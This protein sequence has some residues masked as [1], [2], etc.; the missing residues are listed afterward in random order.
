MTEMTLEN[1]TEFIPPA[2]SECPLRYAAQRYPQGEALRCGAQWFDFASLDSEVSQLSQWAA[3]Q[4]LQRGQR[5]LLISEDK[6]LILRLLLVALRAGACLVVVN[7]RAPVAQL[8]RQLHHCRPQ[9]LIDPDAAL[10]AAPETM[11]GVPRWWPPALAAVTTHTPG[12]PQSLPRIAVDPNLPLSGVFTSGSSGTPKLALHSYANHYHSASGSR[13]LIALGPGD[14]WALT[15]PL[16]HIGGLAILFRC[17]Q[18]GACMQLPAA[19]QGLDELLRSEPAPT[20]LSAVT[21]QLLRLQCD[22]FPLADCELRTLLL[23]GSAFPPP[24]LAWLAEAPLQVLISYGLTEMSSQVMSGPANTTGRLGQLLPGRELCIGAQHELLVRGPT[25]FLGYLP[26]PEASADQTEGELQ[27]PLDSDGW[28]HTRDCGQLDAEGGLYVFGRLDNQFISGGENIQPEEIEGVLL[29]Y[30][31][32]AEAY[33]VP[34]EDAEY[35]QR[36]LAF[37]RWEGEPANAALSQWLRSQL[38]AF[39]SP[40]QLWEL[41]EA[42]RQGLKVNRA[43][44]RQLAEAGNG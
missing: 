43:Y 10:P 40:Q 23:G 24:L 37:L 20:H 19:Q 30:P 33:V 3:Q 4:G 35:G 27:R 41:P 12:E 13:A 16:Y 28:F 21:T 8:Q 14:R 9:A 25:L 34:M 36:P 42:A 2:V 17:L 44:L 38:P 22:D 26:A 29:K 32:V 5:L 39:K 6:G 31:G 1:S 7:P 18:A 11:Q 15:L